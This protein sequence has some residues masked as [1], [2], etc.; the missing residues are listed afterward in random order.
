[1]E[2]ID[3]EVYQEEQVWEAIKNCPK[4]C[5]FWEEIDAT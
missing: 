4:D 3:L 2:V 5:I 1:M